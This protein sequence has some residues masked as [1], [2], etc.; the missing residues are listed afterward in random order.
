MAMSDPKFPRLPQLSLMLKPASAACNLRC[1]YCFYALDLKTGQERPSLPGM[2]IDSARLL[3]D[4]ALTVLRPGASLQLIFQGGEPC[5]RGLDFFQELSAYVDFCQQRQDLRVSY[6]LQTN[7]LFLNAAWLDYLKKRDFLVGLSFDGLIEEHDRYRL[8]AQGLGTAESV[9]LAQERLQEAAVPYNI[10]ATLTAQLARKPREF[11]AFALERGW[12]HIQCTPCMAPGA[13]QQEVYALRPRLY[14]NFYK[15]LFS[16]WKTSLEQGRYISVKLFDDLCNLYLARWETACGLLGRC[17][18]QLV[19]EADGSVYP[20][21][22]YVTEACCLGNIHE[23]SL[24]EML[25]SKNFRRFPEFDKSLPAICGSCPVQCRGGCK[26]LFPYTHVDDSG[27]CGFR[28]LLE[29]ILPE[30][31]NTARRVLAGRHRAT[32]APDPGPSQQ[33]PEAGAPPGGRL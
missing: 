9:L 29:A 11:W 14:Y 10:L 20:C 17:Q 13:G 15:E 12:T 18:P 31:L 6:A 25:L 28:A 30:L 2:N 5:L 24:E 23:S 16:C 21:D 32:S 19:V 22:F 33:R 4:R 8:D 26:R 27:F 7:G 3:I 1:R